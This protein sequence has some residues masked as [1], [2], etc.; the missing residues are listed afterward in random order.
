MPLFQKKKTK[1]EVEIEREL[2]YSH[3][4]RTI[5]RHIA[6]CRKLSEKYWDQGK[7]AAQLGDEKML[8]QF[9]LGYHSMSER[10]KKAERLL[11]YMENIHLQKEQVKLTGEFV[12]FAS[13]MSKSLSEGVSV[14][15]V[16][17]METELSRALNESE[18]AD[19]SLT[20][21]LDRLNER[22]LATPE[23]EERGIA[24]ITKAMEDEA[25]LAEKEF[26]VKIEERLKQIEERMKEGT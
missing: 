4:R 7:R 2:Q 5:E 11:M 25:R 26:D 23:I 20:G 14:Q 9:S 8:R 1:E 17:Q 10:V 21:V 3:A 6:N 22:I 16:A 15:G 18:K 19:M 13:E 12:N 24:E